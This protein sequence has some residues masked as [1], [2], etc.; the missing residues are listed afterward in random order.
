LGGGYGYSSRTHGLA[1]DALVEAAI[2]LANGT[3][4]TA[5]ATQNPD[6]FWALRGAGASYGIVTSMKFQ[7]FAAPS[8]NIVYSYN[9]NAGSA[10]NMKS[11]FAALQDYA[12][13]TAMPTEMN[14]RLFIQPQG[15]R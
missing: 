12:N 13:S 14:M 9:I 2:V 6:I 4:A 10:A 15:V 5:S 7:T 8:Q 11:V 3:L 1:S